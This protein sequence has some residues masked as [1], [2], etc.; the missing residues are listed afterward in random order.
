MSCFTAPCTNGSAV[1]ARWTQYK[2]SVTMRQRLSKITQIILD[3]F[4]FCCKPSSGK[5]L[6]KCGFAYPFLH[7]RLL[8]KSWQYIYHIPYQNHE[9][10]GA[11]F[12]R[13]VLCIYNTAQTLGKVEGQGRRGWRWMD[14]VKKREYVQLATVSCHVQ[15]GNQD[16]LWGRK[17]HVKMHFLIY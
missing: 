4:P 5:G 14:S 17:V 16:C 10:D 1:R 12:N 11:D 3:W 7:T 15:I 6:P 2:N 8:P 9:S 13:Y